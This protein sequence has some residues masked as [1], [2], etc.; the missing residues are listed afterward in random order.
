MTSTY[1]TIAAA[2]AFSCCAVGAFAAPAS[3]MPAAKKV[4]TIESPLVQQVHYKKK[5]FWKKKKH[6]HWVKKVHRHHGHKVVKMYKV[7]R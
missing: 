5:H 3:A 2:V 6:C 7:C 4:V 1:R